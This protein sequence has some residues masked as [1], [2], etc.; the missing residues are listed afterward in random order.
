MFAP[1]NDA[2]SWLE[3]WHPEVSAYYRAASE[4]PGKNVWWPV[5]NA[6]ILDLQGGQDP[7]RPESSRNELKDQLGD[8]VTVGVIARAGHAMVPE[9]PEAISKAIADWV[10]SLPP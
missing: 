8:K 9:Q 10:R 5:T 6:P 4:K 3:G 1:G 7:W 2:S